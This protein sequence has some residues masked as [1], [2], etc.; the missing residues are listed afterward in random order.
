[1]RATFK[2]FCQCPSKTEPTDTRLSELLI[3]I[4]IIITID[5]TYHTVI[6]VKWARISMIIKTQNAYCINGY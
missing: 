3:C 2:S 4:Y 6:T 5:N 1:M